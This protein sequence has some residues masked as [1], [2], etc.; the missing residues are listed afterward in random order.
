MLLRFFVGFEVDQMAVTENGET[1]AQDWRI[2]T[3][4][5]DVVHQQDV[6]ARDFVV[7][8]VQV[9]F[10]IGRCDSAF[11]NQIG[12]IVVERFVNAGLQ[13][14]AI[15]KNQTVIFRQENAGICNRIQPLSGLSFLIENDVAK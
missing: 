1:I 9:V 14:V 8:R 3:L 6:V 10:A 15:G 7:K 12:Q 5:D 2:D 11:E 13:V 4:L